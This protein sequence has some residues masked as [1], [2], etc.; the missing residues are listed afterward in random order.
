MTAAPMTIQTKHNSSTFIKANADY[1]GLGNISGNIHVYTE[2]VIELEP[3]NSLTNV[4]PL[5]AGDI[6]KI[7]DQ[8]S[9]HWRKLFNVYAKL[10]FE[11]EDYNYL[12]WQ[13]LRDELLL[14]ESGNYALY[15]GKQSLMSRI[16]T[17]VEPAKIQ[18]EKIHIVMGKGFAT[19]C[20]SEDIL[21]NEFTW[22]DNEFAINK[23]TNTIICPYFDYRQLTNEKISRLVKFIC[24]LNN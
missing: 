24:I 1:F 13:Q 7:A 10:V 3:Y 21:S 16:N 11:V 9:N 2:N 15:F 14:Q 4:I 8:T 5:N 18:P 20:F 23:D 12:T 17:L 19:R 6:K 22:I